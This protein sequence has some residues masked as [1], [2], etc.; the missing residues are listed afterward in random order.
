MKTIAELRQAVAEGKKL[1]WNDPDPIE[2]NNYNICFIE[3]IDALEDELTDIELM[4][5]PILIQYNDGGSE[6]EV[7]LHEIVIK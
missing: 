1:Y 6:A 2:G 3:V 7:F 4:D 5:C